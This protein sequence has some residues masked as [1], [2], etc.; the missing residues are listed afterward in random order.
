MNPSEPLLTCKTSMPG[1]P[2]ID[3]TN[4]SAAELV[5]EHRRK[6]T[7]ESLA[8]IPLRQGASL[9][10][11]ALRPL[12]R[13]EYRYLTFQDPGSF[14]QL[15]AAAEIAITSVRVGSN[16]E[17]IPTRTV[18]TGVCAATQDGSDR[19]FELLGPTGLRELG[20]LAL[21]RADLGDAGP[22]ALPPG[23]AP[24]YSPR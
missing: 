5:A 19:L 24:A 9:T 10:L 20:A 21:A 2:A 7:R 15:E 18:Q 14:V 3:W 23:T 13:A 11:Y 22:F 16:E 4:K 17:T 8:A 1:D 12:S 6:R